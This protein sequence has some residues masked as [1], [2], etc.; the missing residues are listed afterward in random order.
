M[1]RDIT[2]I[3][4]FRNQITGKILKSGIAFCAKVEHE[5]I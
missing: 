4:R 5:L 1:S 2:E 3:A